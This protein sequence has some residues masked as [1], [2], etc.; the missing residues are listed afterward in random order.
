MHFRNLVIAAFAIAVIGVA[1]PAQCGPKEI[2]DIAAKAAPD[3][4]RHMYLFYI[5][6]RSKIA[7]EAKGLYKVLSTNNLNGVVFVVGSEDSEMMVA[8]IY[9]AFQDVTPGSLAGCHFIFVGSAADREAVAIFVKPS[10][11]DFVFA[12]Y[13]EPGVA[14]ERPAPY[15]IDL[16]TGRRD[17]GFMKV[18]VPPG[19]FIRVEQGKAVF[20]T[21]EDIGVKKLFETGL[22]VNVIKD[23]P[24]RMSKK[25]SEYALALI[26]QLTQTHKNYGIEESSS[27]AL[28]SFSCIFKAKPPKPPGDFIVQYAMATGNDRTG[29][30][31]L[32][33]F[34]SPEAEWDEA[35]KIGQALLKSLTF[36][37]KF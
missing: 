32:V 34:E 10:G 4:T 7:A 11:V 1:S 5:P 19:W 22:S 15:T 12:E 6:P 27:G 20:I 36:D 29:T 8:V 30:V 16:A 23:V 21:K 3:G 35:W 24:K 31:F 37:E 2:A 17:F 25:P 13:R 14:N 33:T 28:K 18:N 9:R 26:T